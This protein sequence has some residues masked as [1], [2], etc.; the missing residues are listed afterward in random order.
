MIKGFLA[1]FTSG[2]IFRL[3]ILTGIMIGIFMMFNLSDDQIF[4]VFYNPL[5]YIFGLIVSFIYAFTL[6]RIYHKGGTTV[7]WRATTYSIFGHFVSYV[8][9]VIFSCLFIFTISFGGFD[10]NNDDADYDIDNAQAQELLR[11][12]QKEM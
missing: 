5:F 8:A 1:L 7:D 10:N 6:K 4:E 11:R 2:I 9:A 3:P 12:L